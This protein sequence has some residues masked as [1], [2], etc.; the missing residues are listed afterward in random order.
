M[1]CALIGSIVGVLF[2]GILSDKLGRKRT[3]DSVGHTLFHVCLSV[4]RYVQISISWWFYRIVGGVG[5]G[6]VFPLYPSLYIPR[7]R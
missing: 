3:I 7:C 1:G 4:V 2:A 5:I 6:V